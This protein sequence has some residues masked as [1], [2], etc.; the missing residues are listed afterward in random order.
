MSE[1]PETP[2]INFSEFRE[3]E[4]FN[5]LT[6]EKFTD[7]SPLSQKVTEYNILLSQNPQ[8]LNLWLEFISLQDQVYPFSY[9]RKDRKKRRANY[10]RKAAIYE[11]A[12]EH[13]NSNR[14]ILGYVD[15]LE[16]IM[17]PTQ[18]LT[19]YDEFLTDGE[20]EIWRVYL[21]YRMRNFESF[22]V[23]GVASCYS[24]CLRDING[25]SKSFRSDVL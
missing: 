22:S 8:S 17:D 21:N 20:I 19:K 13:I 1:D 7:A 3:I 14:L 10:E 2:D 9:T 11:K 5:T 4:P 15:I 25:M 18:L 24:E 23:Q 12:M 6:T 16:E